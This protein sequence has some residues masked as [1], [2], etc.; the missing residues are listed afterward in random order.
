MVIAELEEVRI[1]LIVNQQRGWRNMN[2]QGDIK[3][4]D[5]CLQTRKAPTLEV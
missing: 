2:I 5:E 3:A 4:I 1:A